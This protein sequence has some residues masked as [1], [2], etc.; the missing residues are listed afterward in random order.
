MSDQNLNH[1]IAVVTGASRGIGRAIAERL[2][3]AGATVVIA[4]RSIDASADGLPGTALEVVNLIK[5]RDGKADAI[6]CD[7]ENDAS[8]A[9]LIDQVIKK[10]GRIDILVNNAG[11]AVLEPVAE[12]KL[13]TMRA[14]AEQYVFAPLDLSLRAIEHMK[15]QGEGWIVNLGSHSAEPILGPLENHL[16]AETGLAY[17]GAL[18]AAVHRFTIGFAIELLAHNIAVNA[19]APVLAIATPGVAALGMVTPEMA[20]YFERIEHIAEAALALV[21]KPP[22]EQ[23]GVIAFSHKFLDEI[24]RSTRTLDGR[25]I[26]QQRGKNGD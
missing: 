18:K 22:R 3:S 26:L 12:M 20:P 9:A 10:H 16:Q 5:S 13:V 7:V 14:Q 1:R 15:Q 19:V 17:Y 23:T 25:E 8:R 2:A 21:S 11:R 24:G 4:A 6:A